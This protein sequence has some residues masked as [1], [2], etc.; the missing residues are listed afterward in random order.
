TLASTDA[1]SFE[2]AQTMVVAGKINRT[3]SRTSNPYEL[4]EPLEFQCYLPLEQMN[5]MAFD[6]VPAMSPPPP[7]P[8]PAP[9]AEMIVVTAARVRQVVQEDLGDLKAYR[10][11]EA[12]TVAARSQKQVAML[13]KDAVPVSVLYESV[14]RYTGVTP[15][16]V[17]LRAIN[18]QDRG[19]GLPLPAGPVAL[20]ERQGGRELLIG[21]SSTDDKAVGEA[22]ELKFSEVGNVT[23]EH[24]A[25]PDKG[26]REPFELTLRNANPF[27]IQFEAE[28]DIDDA[29]LKRPSQR[30][31]RKDGRYRWV[32]TVPANGST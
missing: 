11:P 25:L 16:Q 31:V 30:L 5:K 3:T 32:A 8:P 28:F 27:P 26:K 23:L 22:V 18:K 14:V 10:V 6:G 24:K 12:T 13:A 19:L 9:A 20:F 21:E 1:T 15:P 2:N 7:P 17:V 4:A 29:L